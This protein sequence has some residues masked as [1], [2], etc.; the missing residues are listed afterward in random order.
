MDPVK[1]SLVAVLH[2]LAVET[3]HKFPY[4][5][6]LITRSRMLSVVSSSREE[7]ISETGPAVGAVFTVWNGQFFEEV[8]TGD[9][10]LDGLATA[11][12]ELV[13]RPLIHGAGI[14]EIP[15]D[16][17]VNLS[18]R[19][20]LQIDPA[21]VSLEEKMELCRKGRE[22]ASLLDSRVVEAQCMYMEEHV[23]SLFVSRESTMSQD[24]SR[25]LYG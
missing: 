11:A 10:S 13:A 6:A 22:R 18:Y 9:L 7:H 15:A 5:S 4:A 25:V 24:I 8:A 12:R 20:P 16:G 2:Q 3:L 19:T 1:D 23:D 17:A 21:A 14:P